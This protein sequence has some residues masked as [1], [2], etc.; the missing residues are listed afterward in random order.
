MGFEQVVYLTSNE[1]KKL[2]KKI[3][4]FG[5]VVDLTCNENIMN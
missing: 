5:E 2:K 3:L 4:G 1:T